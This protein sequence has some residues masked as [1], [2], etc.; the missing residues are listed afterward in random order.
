MMR[1]FDNDPINKDPVVQIKA[2]TNTPMNEILQ[3]SSDNPI[4]ALM[5]L[6]HQRAPGACVARPGLSL[7]SSRTRVVVDQVLKMHPTF[8]VINKLSITGVAIMKAMNICDTIERNHGK[9]V[10]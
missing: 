2:S 4:I 8:L 3:H 6:E 5:V 9:S 7:A 1:K 10:W